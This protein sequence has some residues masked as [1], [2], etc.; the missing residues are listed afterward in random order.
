M[1]RGRRTSA[2][3][4]DTL[5]LAAAHLTRV[6]I[7]AIRQTHTPEH[8]EGDGA[9]AQQLRAGR[10][11]ERDLDVFAGRACSEDVELLEDEAEVFSAHASAAPFAKPRRIHAVELVAAGRG[12][13]EQADDVEHRRL[14]RA[15]STH[16]R[17]MLARGDV[18]VD[19]A[20]NVQVFPVRQG[21]RA[22]HAAQAHET[23][24]VS[25]A[26]PEPPATPE[27]I[28]P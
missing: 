28:P 18:Q 11:Q 1:T 3:D 2:R 12:D 6:G 9:P 14:T 26:L 17:H 8:V 7:R 13:I 16:D 4:R 25:A 22:G 10:V 20:Q 23:H 5:L 19:A 21:D 27:S 15:R 24:C